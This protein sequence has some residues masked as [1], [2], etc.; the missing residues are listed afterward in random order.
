M[1]DAQQIWD[2]WFGHVPMTADEL[3]RRMLLWFGAAEAAAQHQRDAEIRARF[4][5]WV[6]RAADGELAAWAMQPR[7]RLCL[8]ILLDQFP[9]NIHRGTAFAFAYDERALDLAL[10]GIE[11]GADIGLDPIENLFFYL[12]LQHAESLAIQERAVTACGRL[13]DQAPDSLKPTFET[14]LRYAEQHREIVARFGRFPHR[15][16][17]LGRASTADELDYLRTANSFGQ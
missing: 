9:R 14:T 4:G 2:F 15:N 8:I 17:V 1:D 13:L 5:R 10:D 16:H 12:P 7:G 6:Q 11:M 3:Q